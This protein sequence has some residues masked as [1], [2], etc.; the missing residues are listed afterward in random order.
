MCGMC[1]TTYMY[2]YLPSGI[3]TL[4]CLE[5]PLGMEVKKAGETHSLS[6]EDFP[7]MF[8]DMASTWQIYTVPGLVN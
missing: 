1:G 8:D 7:A 4:H 6:M 2:I 3:Q 5:H